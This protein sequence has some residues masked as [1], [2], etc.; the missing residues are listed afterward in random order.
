VKRFSALATLVGVFAA[1]GAAA[2]AS[3][4]KIPAKW[5][6]CTVVNRRYPHGVGKAHAH[7]KTTGTPVTDFKRNTKLYNQAM[8]YN[9]SLDRDHDGIACEKP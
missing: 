8:H 2:N 6:N 3:Q 7:D 9:K 5:K 1:T 4:L